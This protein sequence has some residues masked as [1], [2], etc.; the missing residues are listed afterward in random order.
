MA[1]KKEPK[2]DDRFSWG[3]NDVTFVPPN[4]NKKPDDKKQQ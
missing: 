1:D 3:K 2:R 4:E